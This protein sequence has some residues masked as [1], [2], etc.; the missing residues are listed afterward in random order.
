MQER[1]IKHINV[2]YNV[3]MCY[4]MQE[5]CVFGTFVSSFCLLLPLLV[6]I[7]LYSLFV[8]S[9]LPIY[10]IRKTKRDERPPIDKNTLI[11]TD[12]FE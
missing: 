7:L 5:M 3:K 1:F 8:R 11:I 12:T 2:L 10:C 6:E 4:A 9:F